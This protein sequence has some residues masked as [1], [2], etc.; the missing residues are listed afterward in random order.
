[1]NKS[2]FLL[3]LSLVLFGLSPNATGSQKAFDRIKTQIERNDIQAFCEKLDNTVLVDVLQYDNYYSRRQAATL[4]KNF[5]REH[6]VEQFS[7]LTTGGTRSSNFV[8]ARMRSDDL[9]FLMTCSISVNP[10]SQY[11]IHRIKI[12]IDK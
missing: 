5:F 7:I 3:V 2:V 9:C 8:I 12:E 4:V 6:P 10:R 1:M 11:K